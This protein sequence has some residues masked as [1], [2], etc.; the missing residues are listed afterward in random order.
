MSRSVPSDDAL[1]MLLGFGLAWC[2]SVPIWAWLAQTDI[3]D[4]GLVSLGVAGLLSGAVFVVGG[5][6]IALVSHGH[7]ARPAAWAGGL[8]GAGWWAISA[9]GVAAILPSQELV[10]AALAGGKGVSQHEMTA[11]LAP[12]VN[13]GLLYAFAGVWIATALG[14][15]LAVAGAAAAQG[16]RRHRMVATGPDDALRSPLVVIALFLHLLLWLVLS[17]ALT[18]LATGIANSMA[19]LDD[20]DPTRMAAGRLA[21]YIAMGGNAVVAALVGWGIVERRAR[22]GSIFVAGLGAVLLLATGALT[23]ATTAVSSNSAEVALGGIVLAVILAGGLWTGYRVRTVGPPPHVDGGWAIAFALPVGVA[24]I[25]LAVAGPGIGAGLGIAMVAV[26]AIGPLVSGTG[27]I[28]ADMAASA[29]MLTSILLVSAF[30]LSASGIGIMG[31]A[32]GIAGAIRLR[33]DGNTAGAAAI[34]VLGVASISMPIAAAMRVQKATDRGPEVVDTA[35]QL[36]TAAP[37]EERASNK[38]RKGSKNRGRTKNRDRT[39]KAL[40]SVLSGSSEYRRVLLIDDDDDAARWIARALLFELDD[41]D[42]TAAWQD[43][44]QRLGTRTDHRAEL[45]RSWPDA[46][47]AP[48]DDLFTLVMVALRT[49]DTGEGA[50]PAA[51][52]SRRRPKAA[53]GYHLAMRACGGEGPPSPEQLACARS[54]FELAT[55]WKGERA[56][57]VLDGWVRALLAADDLDGAKSAVDELTAFEWRDRHTAAAAL[58]VALRTDDADLVTRAVE[59]L[60]EPNPNRPSDRRDPG[61]SLRV[62]RSVV[63]AYAA[64]GRF[65]EAAAAVEVL[66]AP[67]RLSAREEETAVLA[68]LAAAVKAFAEGGAV[69]PLDTC[70]AALATAEA[71]ETEEATALVLGD[72]GP[73]HHD[74]LHLAA[75]KRLSL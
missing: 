3:P 22:T 40:G 38:R 50:G 74:G 71:E 58:A 19:M 57:I 60:E 62:T 26:P 49:A 33:A 36:H 13:D 18:T 5:A 25:M 52:V 16:F 65:E 59:A 9:A 27:S 34:F 4:F 45:V 44:R 8:G 30:A 46:A 17:A 42:A 35:T 6:V 23:V 43:A 55:E 66:A 20:P 48:D 7:P 15:A 12:A 29:G 37:G 64:V 73:C 10:Q 51:A 70:L 14:A 54:A 39:N 47:P 11:L 21:P 41:V 53:L 32:G 61:P 63:D 24:A 75:R 68:P 31:L 72:D 67:A 69:P 28:A 2:A 56:G 1:A